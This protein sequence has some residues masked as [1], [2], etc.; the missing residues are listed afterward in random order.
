M[1]YESEGKVC[2]RTTN[3]QIESA[4]MMKKKRN[5]MNESGQNMNEEIEEKVRDIDKQRE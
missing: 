4:V 1:S 5:G 3:R 2:I